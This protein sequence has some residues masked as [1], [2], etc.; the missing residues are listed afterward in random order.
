MSF[1]GSFVTST[2]KNIQDGAIKA[3]ASWDP[4]TVGETQL[5]EWNKKAAELADMAA[6]AAAE[7]EVQRKK[8]FGIESDIARFT[9][10][11]EKLAATNEAAA[12][13]AADQALALAGDLDTAKTVLADAESWAKETR[14]SAEAAQSKVAKGRTAIEQAKRD[15]ARAKQEQT[16]AEQRLRDRERMAGITNNIDGA[17]MAIAALQAN[18]AEAKKKAAAA[19]IRTGVLN[20][21]ADEDAAI[22]AALAEVD[23]GPRPQSLAEKLA[24]L[25]H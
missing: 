1:F 4:E 24:A 22:A 12:N 2:M 15:Q 21:G 6:Q 23:G 11:A 5:A 19:N 17:D 9:A 3:L 7:L 18:A 13:K 25:K 16:I 8:V 10:A 20:K 14:A